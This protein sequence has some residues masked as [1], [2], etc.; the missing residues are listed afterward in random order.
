MIKTVVVGLAVPPASFVV[1]IF[2]GLLLRRRWPC[3]GKWLVRLSSI[4]LLL[5]SLR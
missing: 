1:L 4:A 3:G 2:A 5:C